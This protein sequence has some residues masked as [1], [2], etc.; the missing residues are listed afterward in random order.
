MPAA[1]VVKVKTRS[2]LASAAGP[3]TPTLRNVT[4]AA[5]AGGPAL[6]VGTG[7]GVAVGL[8][9]GEGLGVGDALGLGDGL[10][11]VGELA[12]GDGDGCAEGLGLGLGLGDGDGLGLALLDGLAEADAVGLGLG[13]ELGEGDAVLEGDGLGLAVADGKGEAVAEAE[14]LTE[15]I[16]SEGREAK[17][18]TT[19][20]SRTASRPPSPRARARPRCSVTRE[21]YSLPPSRAR[22]SRYRRDSGAMAQASR[23]CV[24]ASFRRPTCLRA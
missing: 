18:M 12:V 7:S 11:L 17:L 23:M 14:G 3:S 8:G 4:D 24:R 21:P 2:R 10:A 15:G 5:P 16:G 20:R 19:P 22:A 9:D 6:A 1:S 13:L